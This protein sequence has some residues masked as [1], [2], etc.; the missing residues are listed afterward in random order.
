MV[1]NVTIFVKVE[2]LKC[3]GESSVSFQYSQQ[4]FWTPSPRLSPLAALL[5][6]RLVRSE[7]EQLD[8]SV[9]HCVR[10]G[11]VAV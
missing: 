10:V 1:I 7:Q 6:G 5:R 2:E 3:L 4:L 8:Y 9:Y 11:L